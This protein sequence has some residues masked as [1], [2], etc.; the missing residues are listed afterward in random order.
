MFCDGSAFWLGASLI[1][2]RRSPRFSLFLV[3]AEAIRGPLAQSLSAWSGGPVV[4]SGPLRIASFADLSVEASGVDLK[5]TPGRAPSEVRAQSVTAVVQISSLFR[6]KL[7]FQKFVVASP[8]VVFRRGFT[9]TASDVLR[10]WGRSP[11]LSPFGRKP[12]RRRRIASIP[13]F[14]PRRA[15]G[16]YERAQLN[17]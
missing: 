6:G 10:A 5:S 8:H 2:V 16:A 9:G 12:F 11:G 3:D 15:K 1:A 4:I 7:E 14:L 13:C 17:G